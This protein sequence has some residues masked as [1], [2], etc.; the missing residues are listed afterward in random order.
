M[1][2]KSLKS[3]QGIGN[4][5]LDSKIMPKV[6]DTHWTFAN[7]DGMEIDLMMIPKLSDSLFSQFLKDQANG[8]TNQDILYKLGQNIGMGQMLFSA[9]A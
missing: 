5:D 8:K 6:N 3:C 4:F 2:F 1:I 7:E 9:R